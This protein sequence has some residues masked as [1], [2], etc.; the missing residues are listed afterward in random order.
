M[1]SLQEW[2]YCWR[3]RRIKFY[4][5][6][7]V[8]KESVSMSKLTIVLWFHEMQNI[9]LDLVAKERGKF[10]LLFNE[11]WY[12][13]FMLAKYFLSYFYYY[14]VQKRI[15]FATTCLEIAINVVETS[16]GVVYCA[17]GAVLFQVNVAWLLERID[18]Q[19]LS[20]WKGQK[21]LAF[22]LLT[23]GVV[24]F[25]PWELPDQQDGWFSIDY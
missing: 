24:S 18:T 8:F 9:E 19:D 23:L 11:K 10:N 20:S 17:M 4:Y 21:W 3:Y 1:G 12:W 15:P 2:I 22:I 25:R 5:F 7:F 6:G 16:P 14:W 13:K